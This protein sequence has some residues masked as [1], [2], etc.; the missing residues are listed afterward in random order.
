M[1]TMVKG[2]FDNFLAT[3]EKGLRE[4]DG[5]HSTG[6]SV[7]RGAGRKRNE[8]S[9]HHG[10]NRSDRALGDYFGAD[11]D[12]DLTEEEDEEDEEEQYDTSIDNAIRQYLAEIGR[13]P[14]LTA[15]QEMKIAWLVAEGDV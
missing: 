1:V 8:T 6:Y 3:S 5:P 4:N 13:F 15:A 12:I 10:S 11:D 2:D 7:K 9:V 14:L